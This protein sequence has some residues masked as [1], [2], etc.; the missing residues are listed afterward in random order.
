MIL[1]TLETFVKVVIILTFVKVVYEYIK[2][3][4]WKKSEFLSKEIKEFLN[5]SKVKTVCQLLDW[6]SRKI[7]I[8]DKKIVVSDDYLIEALKTHSEKSAFTI[9]EAYIRDLFDNFFDKVGFFNIYI[10]NGLV[11]E[12]QVLDYL[13]YYFDII[14]IKGRK[15]ERLVQAFKKYIEYYEFENAKQLIYRL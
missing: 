11:E 12:K 5:D 9:E 2:G 13:S 1:E 6:N 7:E 14:S 15:P 4:N 10:K 8:G 3:L